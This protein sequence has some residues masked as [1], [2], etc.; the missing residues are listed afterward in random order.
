LPTCRPN[1]AKVAHTT[2]KVAQVC[3]TLYYTIP[4]YFNTYST[5]G[6]AYMVLVRKLEEHYLEDP[7][8]DGRKIL[9]LILQET[10]WGNGLV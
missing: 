4:P 10:G 8:T 7:G 2:Q 3:T 9:K 5:A 1:F 6:G